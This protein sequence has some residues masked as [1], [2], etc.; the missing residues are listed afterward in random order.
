ML[1]RVR[2][3]LDRGILRFFRLLRKPSF[4]VPF[5]ARDARRL[6]HRR[7][8]QIKIQAKSVLIYRLRGEA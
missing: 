3:F 5:G 2:A 1:T 7:L 8:F 4:A 6:C